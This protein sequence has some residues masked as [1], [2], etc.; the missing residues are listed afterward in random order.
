MEPP[1]FWHDLWQGQILQHAFL[2]L[3][4]FVKDPNISVQSASLSP[5][6]SVEAFAQFQEFSFVVLDLRL[7]DT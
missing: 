3:L 1:V 7:G 4:Y 2:E 5:A 6:L